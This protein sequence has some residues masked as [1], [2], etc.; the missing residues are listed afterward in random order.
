MGKVVNFR[1]SRKVQNRQVAVQEKK[2]D[3]FRQALNQFQQDKGIDFLKLLEGDEK[4]W[5]RRNLR[6]HS[7]WVKADRNDFE[8]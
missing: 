1:L 6:Y 7:D 3:L 5:Q 8:Y 2:S 4:E